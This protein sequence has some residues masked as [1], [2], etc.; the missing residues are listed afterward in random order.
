MQNK[1]N[2]FARLAKFELLLFVSIAAIIS[3]TL[4]FGTNFTADQKKIVLLFGMILGLALF[5]AF[6]VLSF[7]RIKPYE[8]FLNKEEDEIQ[9]SSDLDEN[10]KAFLQFPIKFSIIGAGMIFGAFALG[11]LLLIIMTDLNFVS[12]IRLTLINLSIC[13]LYILISLH[14]ISYFSQKYIKYLIKIK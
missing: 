9:K 10:I 3:I 2:V 12:G 13:I 4:A 8:E 14:L 5:A 11:T 7:V 6:M 1:F